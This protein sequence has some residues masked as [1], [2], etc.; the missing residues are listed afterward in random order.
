M[1]CHYF[2]GCADVKSVMKWYNE[3]L[4]FRTQV[5]RSLKWVGFLVGLS[6]GLVLALGVALISY[7]EVL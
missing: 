2:E 3:E 4:E 5:F 7:L 1:K 6:I